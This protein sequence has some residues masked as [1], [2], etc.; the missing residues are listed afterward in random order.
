MIL[1]RQ[2]RLLQDGQTLTSNSTSL[3]LNEEHKNAFFFWRGQQVFTKKG[4][5][6]FIVKM[7]DK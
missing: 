4:R 1:R 2:L 5:T 3:D 6:E 7:C